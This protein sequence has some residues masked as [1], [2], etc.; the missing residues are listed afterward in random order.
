[1]EGLTKRQRDILTM[2]H[3]YIS[4]EGFPPSFDDLR[5]LLNVASNQTV[6]DALA[7]LEKK[8]VIKRGEGNAR[9]LSITRKGFEALGVQ[10]LLPLAG[11]SRGG[12]LTEAV[13]AA[14]EWKT[15]GR[16][17]SRLDP[18]QN[19]FLVKVHGD[20]M[21]GVIWDG[22]VVLVMPTTAWSD[23]RNRDIV[24][25]ELD[26]ETTVKRYVVKGGRRYLEPENPKYRPLSIV[27]DMVIQG[28][29]IARL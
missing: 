9:G 14:G 17:I 15:V 26:G 18:K 2:L 22:D 6:T 29:V 10:P 23:L 13:A 12:P 5:S 1:M 4:T 3:Q 28:K 16:E 27:S 19:A 11:A 21:E 25:V 24:L 20:S 7:V 8:G